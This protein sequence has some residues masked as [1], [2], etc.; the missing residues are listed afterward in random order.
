MRSRTASGGGRMLTARLLTNC[1]ITQR[2]ILTQQRK[3]QVPEREYHKDTCKREA[4]YFFV[5]HSVLYL[6]TVWTL[7]RV[8]LCRTILLL[9][10][11]TRG[12]AVP[13]ASWSVHQGGHALRTGGPIR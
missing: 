2:N 1:S 4:G 7:C 10:E 6:V 11:E 12:D 9:T 13:H 8:F 5:A 3:S